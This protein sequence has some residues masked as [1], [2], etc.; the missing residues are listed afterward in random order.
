MPLTKPPTFPTAQLITGTNVLAAE[1]HQTSATSS[2]ITFGLSLLATILPPTPLAITN[3]PSNLT[4]NE[5]SNLTMTVGV[6]GSAPLYQW[7]LNGSAIPGANNASYNIPYVATSNA[8]TYFIMVSNVANTVVSTNFVMVVIADT[9]APT[10]VDADG[11]LSATNVLVSF[12]ERVLAA[13]ATNITNYVIKSTTGSVVPV[14]TATLN[15]NGTNVMLTTGAR[16]AGTNHIL[17]VNNVRDR[18]LASNVILTNS[19]IP[20]ST[21]LNLIALIS[22]WD[23]IQPLPGIDPL[24]PGTGWQTLNFDPAAN[25]WAPA[26]SSGFVYDLANEALPVVR[27]TSL[28]SGGLS[29]Y[30]RQTFTYNG[31]P[32]GATLRLRH[33]I[34]DG[35]VVYLNGEEV[36]RFNMPVG[37]IATNTPAATTIGVAALIGYIDIPVT[38]LV[39]GTNIVAVEMHGIS[40]TDNDYVFALELTGRAQSITNGPV[41]IAG[42]PANRTVLEGQGV[43]FG[44]TAA[45]ATSVQWQ[46]NGTN[47]VGQ[48]NAT[49]TI[50]V[51]TLA[52]NGYTFRVV[53]SG[54]GSSATSSNAFLNVISLTP[55]YLSIAR[56]GTTV[57][58]S[59]TNSG[60]TLQQTTNLLNAST[61]WA[62]VPGPVTVSPYSTNNPTGMKYYRL[63]R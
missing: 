47:L 15:N 5:S 38:S 17:T 60:V 20:I 62:D 61:P 13:G 7:F 44:F 2:D 32:Y 25:N 9:N 19:A 43:T 59:W 46:Q 57:T 3:Q 39:L 37:V 42:Q 10:L 1:V 29:T 54:T 40:Y 26:G 12:S 36:Y 14:L 35:A 18:S 30:F 27:N 50:P 51:T 58:L 33:V 41:V 34:D 53:A 22:P 55:P 4:V 28:S 52:M 16:P 8:G 63:R 24:N 21:L 56:S 48:T 6:S 31:S 23:W 11:T 49:L 45:A